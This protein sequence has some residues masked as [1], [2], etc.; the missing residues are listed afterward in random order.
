MRIGICGKGG[1][2]KTT[3]SSALAKRA[4][5]KGINTWFFDCDVNQAGCERFGIT[6]EKVPILSEQS[7]LLKD[8]LR[9]TN[10]L[11]RSTDDMHK[12]TPPGKGS[13]LI[14]ISERSTLIDTLSYRVSDTL[15]LFRSGTVDRESSGHRCHHYS[16]GSVE[17]ML[18]HILDYER[19]LIIVDM[20]AGSDVFSSPL[21]CY[22]DLIVVL[23]NP[24]SYSF[25]VLR[26]FSHIKP[27]EVDTEIAVVLNKFRGDSSLSPWKDLLGEYNVVATI[28]EFECFNQ[29]EEALLMRAVCA[30]SDKLFDAKH[31]PALNKQLDAIL[32]YLALKKR[33]WNKLLSLVHTYHRINCENWIN[34]QVGKDLRS[35]IDSEFRYQDCF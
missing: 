11:I 33:D 21:F 4:V 28:K 25:E 6:R 31:P 14:S 19:D 12:T 1:A 35:Q 34:A 2:G 13:Q 18:T 16:V 5:Q 32:D 24:S 8:F 23:V 7:L 20:T 22:L 26:D 17:M 10:E 9:G 15:R 30:S 3:I 27:D 29:L